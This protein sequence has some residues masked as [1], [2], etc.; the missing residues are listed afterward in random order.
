MPD[1][2]L[3]TVDLSPAILLGPYGVALACA[4]FQQIFNKKPL[5]LALVL[6]FATAIVT[7]G[8]AAFAA[9]AGLGTS[10]PALGLFWL[11]EM[12]LFLFGGFGVFSAAMGMN[13]MTAPQTP[14]APAP[15]G[16]PPGRRQWNTLWFQ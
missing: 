7:L 1:P 12:L 5:M 16:A 10:L 15:Q 4:A 8:D 13:V 11:K 9:Y 14:K 3:S 2:N 6:S